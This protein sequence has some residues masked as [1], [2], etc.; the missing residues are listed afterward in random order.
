M[1]KI[2]ERFLDEIKL[3]NSFILQLDQLA[4]FKSIA[5]LYLARLIL[6]VSEGCRK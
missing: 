1:E 4:L 6:K 3:N 5:D 2:Y